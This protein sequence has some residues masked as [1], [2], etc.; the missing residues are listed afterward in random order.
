MGTFQKNQNKYFITYLMNKGWEYNLIFF[1][2]FFDRSIF[3]L[4]C[5]PKDS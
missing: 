2:K 1:L 5:R 4:A 3:L